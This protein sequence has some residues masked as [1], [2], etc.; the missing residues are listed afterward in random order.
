MINGQPAD[1]CGKPF[2][3]PQVCPPLHRD[4]V[5]KPLMCKLMTHNVCNG[6]LCLNLSESMEP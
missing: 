3:Q 2:I 1:P 5:A 4:E 6:L